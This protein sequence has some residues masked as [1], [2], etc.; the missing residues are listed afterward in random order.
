MLATILSVLA[1][2]DLPERPD[3]DP[4][5]SFGTDPKP[6]LILFGV[7]FLVAVFGHILKVKVMIAAGILMV[8]LATVILPLVAQ[9]GY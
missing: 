7:G 9:S 5:P 8:F 1:E 6:Y 4:D 3:I 2:F